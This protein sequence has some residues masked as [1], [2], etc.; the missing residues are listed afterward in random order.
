MATYKADPVDLEE[1]LPANLGE[2]LAMTMRARSSGRISNFPTVQ[3]LAKRIEG[4]LTHCS[5]G[6]NITGL[7]V[8]L[9]ISKQTLNEYR[10]GR[11]DTPQ[12][13]LSETLND[14]CETIEANTVESLL[15]G[16]YAQAGGIFILKAHH[17]YVDPRDGP[18]GPPIASDEV[19]GS[20]EDRMQSAARRLAFVMGAVEALPAPADTT[21]EQGAPDDEADR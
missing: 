16:R 1:A 17:G 11:Y 15:S 5:H 4:Y 18:Y 6:A 13:K 19:S 9:G 3:H 2:A 10:R 21:H 12:A 14:A 20:T 8:Y 7:A